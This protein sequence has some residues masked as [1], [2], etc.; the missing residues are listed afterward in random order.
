MIVMS[1]H[2]TFRTYRTALVVY[3]LAPPS[4]CKA[5]STDP[6]HKQLPTNARTFPRH[7]STCIANARLSQ[8]PSLQTKLLPATSLEDAV[9]RSQ[10][11]V[12]RHRYAAKYQYTS[13]GPLSA[14]QNQSN[15]STL[16][17]D[18]SHQPSLPPAPSPPHHA[19]APHSLHLAQPP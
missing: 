14:A 12:P 11:L 5:H 1:V 2:F 9:E 8:D 16:T 18:T 10:K 4:L 7:A 6:W 17:R 15:P 13:T 3:S 19:R